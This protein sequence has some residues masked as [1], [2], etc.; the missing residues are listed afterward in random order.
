MLEKPARQECEPEEVSAEDM[1]KASPR[2]HRASCSLPPDVGEG[3]T[4]GKKTELQRNGELHGTAHHCL[5]R[6]PDPSRLANDS[7]KVVVVSR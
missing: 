6:S 3:A 5:C 7:H 4:S 2:S 1:S